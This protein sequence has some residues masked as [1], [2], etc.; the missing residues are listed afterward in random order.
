[1]NENDNDYTTFLPPIIRGL[2]PNKNFWRQGIDNLR[3]LVK[4]E[5][6]NL[7]ERPFKETLVGKNQRSIAIQKL[8]NFS[9]KLDKNLLFAAVNL[10]D[11]YYI[12]HHRKFKD[13]RE[14]DITALV[15][16][17]IVIAD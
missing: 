16:L 1:M 10:L 8:F 15:S 5:I 14:A 17:A 2:I 6:A 3:K 9:K 7:R 13:Q 4:I 12:Q 11:S